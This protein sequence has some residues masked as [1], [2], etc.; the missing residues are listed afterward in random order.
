MENK[1]ETSV[2]RR[3]VHVTD[4]CRNLMDTYRPAH[5]TQVI[6]VRGYS[7][8]D[9][10]VECKPATV[11]NLCEHIESDPA[12]DSVQFTHEKYIAPNTAL[13][14]E[15]DFKFNAPHHFDVCSIGLNGE[16]TRMI[17]I[18]FQEGPIKE[19]GVNGVA[20]ED[21]IMMV[22]ARLEGFQKSEYA[23]QDNADALEHLYATMDKL[24]IRTKKRIERGVE[25]T[26]KI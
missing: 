15:K 11:Q 1:V 2:V 22:I 8:N 25:G 13:I 6:E 10:L 16:V 7:E 21:L 14:H 9:R 19:N 5:I 24:N 18:D 23:C 12:K 3:E 20:N 17:P 26:S 4:N